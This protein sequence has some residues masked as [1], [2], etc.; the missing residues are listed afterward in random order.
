VQG[1]GQARITSADDAHIS[2]CGPD[3]RGV[4]GESA[5]GGEIPGRRVI[6]DGTAPALAAGLAQARD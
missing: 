6:V 3:E 4:A 5:R 2:G 1:C